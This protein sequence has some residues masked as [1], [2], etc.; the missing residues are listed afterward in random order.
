RPPSI[1]TVAS[2]SPC[3]QLPQPEYVPSLKCGAAATT[4]GSA[5]SASATVRSPD[6]TP[7]SDGVAA[8][9]GAVAAGLTGTAG[10]GSAVAVE[11]PGAAAGLSDAALVAAL[12]RTSGAAELASLD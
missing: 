12:G 11:R 9:A 3:R 1:V 6:G 2:R 4:G 5:A 7:E 10:C 8:G